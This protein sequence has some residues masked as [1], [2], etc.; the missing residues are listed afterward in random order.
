MSNITVTTEN[1]NIEEVIKVVEMAA[2]DGGLDHK[3][4]LRLTLLAEELAGILRGI[5]GDVS[6][7]FKVERKDNK[8]ELTL[9]SDVEMNKPM[10]EQFI[11]ASTTGKNSIT[12][13][14]MGKIKEMI[15]V[16][17]LPDEY[18]Y[19]L[20]SGLS[21]GLMTMSS[22]SGMSADMSPESLKWSMA[23]YRE[24]LK[25]KSEDQ[26]VYVTWDELEKSIVGSLADD[27][28]VSV[29]GSNV[30]IVIEKSF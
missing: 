29:E 28:R 26:D 27:V 3:S 11:S 13:G 17:L 8:Y 1:T 21:L 16:A 10:R 25:Q 12:K 18:G 19:S 6:A 7:D 24:A 22:P 30:R 5:A 2:A 20:L 23:Q 15:A 9:S 14:F 4:T